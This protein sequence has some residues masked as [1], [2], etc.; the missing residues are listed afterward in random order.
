MRSAESGST[1]T[2]PCSNNIW[3]RF[4][5][6]RPGLWSKLSEFLLPP[7]PKRMRRYRRTDTSKRR[8]GVGNTWH[9]GI[10]DADVCP[11]TALPLAAGICCPAVV[12]PSATLVKSKYNYVSLL[13]NQTTCNLSH[14]SFQ[15]SPSHHQHPSP[16]PPPLSQLDS[17]CIGI[18][19]LNATSSAAKASELS[20]IWMKK[21]VKV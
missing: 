13:F 3:G 5:A 19:C 17:G 1:S 15:N 6:G 16:S 10:L 8:R 4:F 21:S 14:L 9:A 20:N 2:E 11:I 18:G 7:R 12:F